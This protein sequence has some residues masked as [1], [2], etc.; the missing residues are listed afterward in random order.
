MSFEKVRAFRD[1]IK[2]QD[3]VLAVGARDALEARLIERAG[4]DAIWSSGFAISASY[5]VP[6][7]S[8]I[9]MKQFLDVARSIYEAVDIPIIADCD[10]GFGNAINVIYTVKLYEAAGVAAICI[11]DKKFPKDTSLLAGGRQELLPAEEFTGKIKAAVDTRKNNDLSIIARTE[12]LIAG[13]GQEEALERAHRYQEAGADLILIHSKSK[14]PDEIIEFTQRWDGS[15]PLVIVPTNYPSLTE[16]A[17]KKL[18]KIKV[19]IYA[20]QVLRAAVKA[21]EEVLSEIRH[22]K[23]IH[24]VE[25]MTVPVT[26]IFELQDVPLMKENEKKYM[27]QEKLHGE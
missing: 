23:G 22:V 10:T 13:W 1:K 26:H 6:D 20:N 27:K 18:K 15:I 3:L 25:K 14:T 7:S 19:V 12:A 8:L 16:E 4:F 24:T 2:N 11:E 9:T 5:G 17:V 21:Q